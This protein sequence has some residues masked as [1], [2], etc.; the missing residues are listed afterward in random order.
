MDKLRVRAS[1]VAWQARYGVASP[2]LLQN[3]STRG[4]VNP[5]HYKASRT[6]YRGAR[7][8]RNGHLY[9]SIDLLPTG[10]HRCHQCYQNQLVKDR[11]GGEPNWMSEARR[12][13]CPQGHEYTR[14]NTYIE[15][16]KAGRRKRHC[17]TCVLDRA[18]SRT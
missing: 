14:D 18:T 1:R 10:G 5:H 9:T 8:C 13:F 12:K 6:P 16:T 11:R 2:Y 17:K 4:C 3:C 15:T 7:Y